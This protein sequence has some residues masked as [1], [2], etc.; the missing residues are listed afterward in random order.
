MI[1]SLTF[2][3][4][5]SSAS[6][7]GSI[8]VAFQPSLKIPTSRKL[9]PSMLEIWRPCYKIFISIL[10]C[11]WCTIYRLT[12]I[13]VIKLC[14][15]YGKNFLRIFGKIIRK[16]V[17]EFNLSFFHSFIKLIPGTADSQSCLGDFRQFHKLIFNISN[18][19]YCMKTKLIFL[20]DFKCIYR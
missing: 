12:G 3:L 14:M 10:P 6:G 13:N 11:K 16:K 20:S 4:P 19:F 5:Q 2:S 18:N 9:R 15:Y 1:W 7:V 8:S 17:P